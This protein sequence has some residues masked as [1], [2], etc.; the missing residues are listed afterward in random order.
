MI[1]VKDFILQDKNKKTTLDFLKL[2]KNVIK[3]NIKSS[4]IYGIPFFDEDRMK[5]VKVLA[6][7]D[8]NNIWKAIVKITNPNSVKSYEKES[9]FFPV[10]WSLTQLFNECEYAYHNMIKKYGTI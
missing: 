3:S 10:K 9:T 4:K 1:K 8:N 2:I 7:Q 5:I 6:Q